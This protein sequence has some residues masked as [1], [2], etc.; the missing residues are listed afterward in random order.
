M[1][2]KLILSIDQG[3]TSTRALVFDDNGHCLGS[4]AHEF[5]QSY[6]RT[7]WVEHDAEEIWASVATVVS[8]ALKSAADVRNVAAIGITNQRE[9]VVLWDRASGRPVAPA[10]V[11][12]DR[13]TASYCRQR[14][15]DEDWIR[16][17]TGLVLDP[18]FSAS[19]INW[20]LENDPDCR[21]RAEA[22]Q[23]A[24]GTI[25]S[26]LIWKLTNGK[27]HVTDVTNASRTLLMDLETGSWDDDLCRYFAVPRSILPRIE[28]SSANFGR[29]A[30]IDFVP[31]EIPI[32]GVAGDQQ[33]ALFG[34]C[35]FDLGDAKC[36]YGTGA[37]LLYHTGNR[38]VHSRHRLLTTRA[39][40]LDHS[41]QFALEGSVFI[42]GAAVQWLRDGIKII[43]HSADSEGLADRS[44]LGQPVIFVPALV[45][46]GAPHWSA[47]AKGALFGLTRATTR[48]EIARAALEGVA[49]QVVDLLDAIAADIGE[50]LRELRVDGG[51]SSNSWFLKFQ[52]DILDIPVLQAPH[53][54]STALG[55]AFLAGLQA[56]IWP[57]FKTLR[58]LLGQPRRFEPSISDSQ[59][60][61]RIESWRRAV[62]AVLEF[63]RHAAP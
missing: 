56:G 33:A 22:G 11:W 17:K 49:Y 18:Y 24:C 27:V 8:R 20:L 36:T 32:S 25:D 13:R 39:A 43:E 35:G 21:R 57:D 52:A 44:D 54:E 15:G 9:T 10:L 16:R 40:S 5:K 14:R 58:C 2:S 50:P 38:P 60:R 47:G 41:P 34:Q 19:K 37:F 6:P 3:T 46:L 4:A 26:F 42:A 28:A 12:Q 63:Y 23:L 53:S 59:R 48:A 51:M 1:E 31:N 7:G 61:A 45:G 29:T 30:G 55:A 62:Q